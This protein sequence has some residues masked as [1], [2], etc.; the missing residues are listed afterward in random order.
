MR[1]SFTCSFP[2]DVTVNFFLVFVGFELL[3]LFFLI[4]EVKKIANSISFVIVIGSRACD[5]IAEEEQL[6]EVSLA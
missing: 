3:L 4:G 1:V 5:G 6:Q 2:S